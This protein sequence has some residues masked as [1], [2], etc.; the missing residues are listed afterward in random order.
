MQP[1]P[2]IVVDVVIVSKYEGKTVLSVILEG[3]NKGAK[4]AL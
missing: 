1:H 4:I 3:L 2:S